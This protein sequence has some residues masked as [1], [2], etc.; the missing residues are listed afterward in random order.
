MSTSEIGFK[1]EKQQ[2][3]NN[4]QIR[5]NYIPKL[6]SGMLRVQQFFKRIYSKIYQK[7]GET[8]LVS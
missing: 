8:M 6:Y 7:T 3:M 5:I 4:N 1:I 2:L